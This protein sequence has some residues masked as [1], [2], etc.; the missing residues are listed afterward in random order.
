MNQA[1]S[2]SEWMQNILLE[3]RIVADMEQ[4]LNEITALDCGC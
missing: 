2:G 4:Q 1:L 3:A